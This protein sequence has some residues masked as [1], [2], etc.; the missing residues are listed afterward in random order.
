MSSTYLAYFSG[1]CDGEAGSLQ[2]N[3]NTEVMYGKVSESVSTGAFRSAANQAAN[4]APNTRVSILQPAL[5]DLFKWFKSAE[6]STYNLMQYVQ[7]NSD[8]ATTKWIVGRHNQSQGRWVQIKE[9]YKA[10]LAEAQNIVGGS[11]MSPAVSSSGAVAPGTSPGYSPVV[12]GGFFSKYGLILGIGVVVLVGGFFGLKTLKR[13]PKAMLTPE[14]APESMSGLGALPE[15]TVDQRRIIREAAGEARSRS[16]VVIVPG[17]KRPKEIGRRSY[18]TT[19]SGKTE[20]AHPNAYDWPKWYHPS[21]L[22]IEVGSEWVAKKFGSG[23]ALVDAVKESVEYMAT[24]PSDLRGMRPYGVTRAS[25]RA[26]E[27]TGAAS[28]MRNIPG[29]GGDIR[30]PATPEQRA[31]VRRSFKRLARAEGKKATKIGEE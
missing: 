18:W 25:I 11:P 30:A 12:E 17:R 24:K 28:H 13:K 23:D 8:C 2:S 16:P 14:P 9:L 27:D 20:I 3:V 29:P 19:P 22:R 6:G 10:A 26:E 4:A 7:Q 5:N 15:L 21:T 1:A 31:R